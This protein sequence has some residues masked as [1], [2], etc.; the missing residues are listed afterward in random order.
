MSPPQSR[1]GSSRTA[2]PDRSSQAD[3]P[4][5]KS[6]QAACPHQKNRIDPSYPHPRILLCGLDSHKFRKGRYFSSCPQVSARVGCVSLTLIYRILRCDFVRQCVDWRCRSLPTF[7]GSQ[8][9]AAEERPLVARSGRSKNSL[10]DCGS[11]R[12]GPAPLVFRRSVRRPHHLGDAEVATV[13]AN[14]VVLFEDKQ[15]CVV[16]TAGFSM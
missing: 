13:D 16:L 15:S 8:K 5:R 7:I 1:R 6:P 11:Q 12:G 14:V 3:R 4:S 10:R 2:P 9:R